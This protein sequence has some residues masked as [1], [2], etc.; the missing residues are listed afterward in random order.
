MSNIKVGLT[1]IAAEVLEDVRKEAEALLHNS[2]NEAKEILKKAKQEADKTYATILSE[3]EAKTK[4]EKQKIKSLT[5]VEKRN[6]LLQTKEQLVDE[7][8]DRAIA[9]LTEFAKTKEYHNT[10]FELIKQAADKVGSKNL[11]LQV[12]SADKIWLKKGSLDKFA[13]KIDA[14]FILEK[15]NEDSIGGCKVKTKDGSIVFDNTFE[16]RLEQL[17]PDLRL[18]VAKILFR[19]EEKENAS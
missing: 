7:A 5:E 14:E 3:T 15:E 18:S 10:L 16:N 4:K 1:A 13:K 6:L 19:T 9:R 12:N 8:F 17:K 11:V 2:E